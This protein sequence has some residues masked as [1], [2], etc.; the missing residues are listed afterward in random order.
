[1]NAFNPGHDLGPMQTYND[2][3]HD[4]LFYTR[5]ACATNGYDIYQVTAP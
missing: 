3:T 2:G 5:I 4:Q 1:M